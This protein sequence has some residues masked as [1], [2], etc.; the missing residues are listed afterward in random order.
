MTFEQFYNY[1]IK[2]SEVF[3]TKEYVRILWSNGYAI[4]QAIH[5]LKTM[6]E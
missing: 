5:S 3:A 6:N 2:Q 1:V 4:E